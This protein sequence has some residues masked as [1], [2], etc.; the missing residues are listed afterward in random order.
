MQRANYQTVGHLTRD[1]FVLENRSSGR[2]SSTN[3]MKPLL[4]LVREA[5][6]V[7]EHDIKF[8]T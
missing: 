2:T 7:H 8:D 5:D 6:L 1:A 4:L 3:K